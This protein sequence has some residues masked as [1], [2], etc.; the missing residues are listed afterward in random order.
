MIECES[1]ISEKIF[2]KKKK[3]K[4]KTRVSILKIKKIAINKTMTYLGKDSQ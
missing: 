4:K 3:T 2:S 1:F